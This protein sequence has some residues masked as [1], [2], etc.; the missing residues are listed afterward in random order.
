MEIIVTTHPKSP[1]FILKGFKDENT[2]QQ[3][4][5]LGPDLDTT[6]IQTCFNCLSNRRTSGGGGGG[7]SF[8]N[9]VSR[10]A[11]VPFL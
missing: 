3:L 10:V 11:L 1:S 8:G 9:C 6:R 5:T 4:G 2:R 7:G